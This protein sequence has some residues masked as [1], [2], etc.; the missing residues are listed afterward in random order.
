MDQ[1]WALNEVQLAFNE[2]DRLFISIVQRSLRVIGQWQTY[3]SK[4][5]HTLEG[6]SSSFWAC[7]QT[8]A[9]NHDWWWFLKLLD[10]SWPAINPWG[11]CNQLSCIE[12]LHTMHG[13]RHTDGYRCIH[14]L[15]LGKRLH[16]VVGSPWAWSAI[17]KEWKP[18]HCKESK[19]SKRRHC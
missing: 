14:E 16:Q 17:W 12:E 1:N 2:V 19:T 5:S 18:R 4:A 9:W 11:L 15:S 8:F 7:R 10:A 13:A 6:C 3:W